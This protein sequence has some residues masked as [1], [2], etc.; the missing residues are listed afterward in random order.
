MATR[1][2]RLA[3]LVCDT[4]IPAVIK[5]HGEYPAIFGRLFRT[6]LPDGIADFAMDP[7]DVRN[8]KEY[9]KMDILDTYDGIVITGSAAS[10]YEDV[11]WINKLVSWVANVANSRPR[12]KIIGICFGHQIIARALGGE[13]VPNGGKWE[14]A[15]AGVALTELGQRIFG[16]PSFNI[17]QMHRD[18]VPSAPPSFHLLGSTS[19]S[20]NQGMVQFSDLDARF[21]EVDGSI[22]P[23]HILTLQ[24]HPE[25]T[26]GIVKEIIRARGK[27]GTMDKDTVEDGLIRAD[28]R[29]DGDGTIGRAIWE[30]LLQRSAAIRV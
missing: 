11:E 28:D 12:I 3:L 16:V 15:I 30:V 14:V 20:R 21:P 13:C 1:I 4:P 26:T 24:G 22:P 23:I 9:P 6:S 7:Y 2:P 8:A 5:D 29:N 18:H 17:Q 25:F 19:V 27:N 10:A